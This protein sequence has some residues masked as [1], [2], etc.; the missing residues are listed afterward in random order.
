MTAVEDAV[1]RL[2]QAVAERRFGKFRGIVTD[3]QD[4]DKRGRVR[5]RVP[6][7]LGDQES[8]WALPCFPY[9]GGASYGWFMVP[10]ND[11]QVWVEFEEGDIN[12]PIWTGVFWQDGGDVPS[13]AAKTDPTT[14]LL[15][16]P[17]GH[18]VQLDDE[19]GT[20]RLRLHHSAGTELLMDENGSIA[21]TDTKGAKVTLDANAG[22]LSIVDSNGSSIKMT[23]SGTTVEDGNGNKVEMA[24]SGLTLEGQQIVVKGTQVMLGGQGGE[25]IIKGTSFLTLFATHTHPTGMGPSGPPIPQGEMS[26]LSSKVMTS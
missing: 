20:E 4:P 1:V 15:Q 12:R 6:A 8:D 19:S 25:P 26:S 2:S 3:N 23:A 11:A 24:A 10:K 16:T 5:V 17:A 7:V 14:V 18:I 22:E 21:L 13:D 9:G